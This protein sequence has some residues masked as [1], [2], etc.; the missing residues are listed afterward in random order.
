[1]AAPRTALKDLAADHAGLRVEN[2]TLRANAAHFGVL[3]SAT[4]DGIF[5]FDVEQGR[6]LTAF[7]IELPD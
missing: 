2:Q 4:Y 1:M 3:F 7:R 5:V 6:V